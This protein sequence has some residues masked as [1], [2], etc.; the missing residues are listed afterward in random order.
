[1]SDVLTAQDFE[2]L[3]GRDI[4]LTSEHSVVNVELK[5]V[6]LLKSPSPRPAPPFVAVF[7][8][9]GAKRSHAQGLYAV[10]LGAR[11]IVGVFLVPIG[12]DGDGMCYEAVFN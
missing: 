3:A 9:R 2:A 5:E 10:D 7:R 1:M 8:E 4:V 12:P 6:Q 11:G